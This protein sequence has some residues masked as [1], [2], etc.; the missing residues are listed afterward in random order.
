[1]PNNEHVVWLR[2]AIKSGAQGADVLDVMNAVADGGALQ[3]EIYSVADDHD[4]IDNT[5][6]EIT[7]VV[8]GADPNEIERNV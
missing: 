8:V 3:D 5:D 1:M 4:A 6:F 7:S 2:V